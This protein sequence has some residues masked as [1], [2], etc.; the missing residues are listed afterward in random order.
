M[1]RVAELEDVTITNCSDGFARWNARTLAAESK[2]DL[3][4]DLNNDLATVVGI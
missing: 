1:A 3:N 2:T 4:T